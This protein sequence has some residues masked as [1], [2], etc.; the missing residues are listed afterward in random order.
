[1][2]HADRERSE[3]RTREWVVLRWNIHDGIYYVGPFPTVDEANTWG[4]ENQGIDPNWQSQHVDPS[5]SIPIRAPGPMPPLLDKEPVSEDLRAFVDWVREERGETKLPAW[6]GDADE[7]GWIP[8]QNDAGAFYVVVVTADPLWVAGPFP[9]HQHAYS[10]AVRNH[11]HDPDFD[12]SMW[13]IVWFDDPARPPVLQ[14][15]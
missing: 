2:S 5:L 7:Y 1:M 8:N 12:N 13:Q 14:H 15:P 4:D 10:W 9:D 6:L 11:E 3:H